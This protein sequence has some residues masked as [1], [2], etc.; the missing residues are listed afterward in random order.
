MGVIKKLIAFIVKYL[1]NIF[2]AKKILFSQDLVTD[3]DGYRLAVG[4][5]TEEDTKN[6][7]PSLFVIKDVDTVNFSV[8]IKD[9]VS[10]AVIGTAFGSAIGNFCNLKIFVTGG[11]ADNSGVILLPFK[12]LAGSQVDNDVAV[13]D[14]WDNVNDA[15]VY[16]FDT[17]GSDEIV[18][19]H[20]NAGKGYVAASRCSIDTILTFPYES[21]E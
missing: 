21:V 15:D 5:N 8:D 3:L 11:H 18:F 20:D 12:Q 17:N 1:K 13:F 14:Y 2:M 10:G 6:A 16:R 4:K 7:L 19:H 9:S